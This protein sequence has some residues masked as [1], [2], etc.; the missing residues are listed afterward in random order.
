MQHLNEMGR[1]LSLAAVSKNHPM[2]SFPVLTPLI[3]LLLLLASRLAAVELTSS[4]SIQTTETSAI[5]TWKT[6]VA[7][8]TRLQY[9]LSASK[10]DQKAGEGVTNEHRVELSGLCKGTSYHFSIGSARTQ[11]TSGQFTTAGAAKA[12]EG[13]LL[14]R[15][16][17]AL[18]PAKTAPPPAAAAKTPN[19]AVAAPSTRQTWGNVDTLQDHFDRHGADFASRS[20]DDYAAQAWRF[21]QRA[22]AGEL[23][24]KLD[25][26]DGTLR[27]YDP[28]TKAFAA[29]NSSGRT[30]TFFRPQSSTYWQRQ[31][32]APVKPAQV[33]FLSR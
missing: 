5:I 32:G 12:A 4:P 22:K 33:P 16:M 29:Y 20:P 8:G 14:K 19:A 3:W 9:G 21:L 24:M 13:S 11:L 15:V 17:E 23:L 26:S 25:D 7:C 27:V 31:P 30:K 28:K 10:L 1:G 18:T 6:D 2:K